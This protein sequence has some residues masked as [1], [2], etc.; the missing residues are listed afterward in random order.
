VPKASYQDTALDD[1]WIQTHVHSSISWVGADVNVKVPGYFALI[2]TSIIP[3]KTK[4]F[5]STAT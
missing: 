3:E 4:F 2:K 1:W 5:S